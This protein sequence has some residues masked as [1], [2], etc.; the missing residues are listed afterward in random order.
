MTLKKNN[1]GKEKKKELFKLNFMAGGTSDFLPISKILDTIYKKYQAG[2]F[3]IRAPVIAFNNIKTFPL[4]IDIDECN[5]YTTIYNAIKNTVEKY[6]GV[7]VDLTHYHFTNQSKPNNH[8]LYF[9]NIIVD[10]ATAFR[11]VTIINS[12]LESN[13]RIDTMN[14]YKTHIRFNGFNKYIKSPNDPQKNIPV[15]NTRYLLNDG[16]DI[17]LDVYKKIHNY[18]SKI[19]KLIKKLPKEKIKQNFIER[20]DAIDNINLSSRKKIIDFYEPH[21]DGR[22]IKKAYGII[23]PLNRGIIC[24]FV[25]RPH[26]TNKSY[27]IIND[28]CIVFGCYSPKCTNMKKVL[29]K[30]VELCN[31]EWSVKVFNNIPYDTTKPSNYSEKKKYFEK[32]YFYSTDDDVLYRRKV[33]WNEK[34]KYFEQEIKIVKPKGLQRFTYDYPEYE[35]ENGKKPSFITTYMGDQY[36]DFYFETTFNPNLY[37]KEE[38]Y[39][40]IF[41]GF[42]FA[43]ILDENITINQQDY[44]EL[45]WFLNDYIKVYFCSNNDIYFNYFIALL[46][47][48]IQEPTKLPQIMIILYSIERG[49]GKSFFW[50]FFCRVIGNEYCYISDF[51]RVFSRFSTALFGKLFIFVDELHIT[52]SKEED[53]VKDLIQKE[54]AIV[55]KKGIQEKNISAYPHIVGNLNG[56]ANNKVAIHVSEQNRRFF[57]L[58]CEAIKKNKKSKMI[59]RLNKFYDNIKMIFLFGEYLTNYEIPYKNQ[60]QWRDARPKTEIYKSLIKKDNVHNF[61]IAIYKNEIDT[62]DYKEGKKNKYLFR[63]IKEKDF[64]IDYKSYCESSKQKPFSRPNFLR[65]ITN[66]EFISM[67]NSSNV[68][69]YKLNLKKLHSD[70]EIIGDFKEFHNP[71]NEISDDDDDDDELISDEEED[72]ECEFIDSDD[73]KEYKPKSV[74]DFKKKV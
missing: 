74:M 39:Y 65:K 3:N 31:N 34:Y 17:T 73:D 50:K 35:E 61:L 1:T 69:Y 16:N 22:T 46:S 56:D 2:K 28:N 67:K 27:L 68:K 8:H 57:I 54:N 49:V 10:R 47:N 13:N 14:R 24:P 30:S 51:E 33:K 21:Y 48:I 53:K 9:V 55:E 44:D 18:N 32:F 23:K 36:N 72:N 6:Y 4:Y 59:S 66:Y 40:N 11:L 25:N 26:N 38:G 62:I 37:I 15:K 19:N 71:N 5:H 58:Y 41:T 29:F 64:Y 45:N 12:Y 52:S 20:Q 42:N 43:K 63:Y 7:D 60:D 70:L